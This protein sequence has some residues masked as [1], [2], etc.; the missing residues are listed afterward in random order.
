VERQ[1]LDGDRIF[2]LGGFLSPKECDDLIAL[3]ERAGYEEATITT[4]FGPVMNKGVRD[5]ARLIHDDPDLAARLWERARSHLPGS[6]GRWRAVGLNERFRFYRY[7]PGEKFA[8]HFDGAYERDSGERSFLTLM[9]YLNG[10]C[11]GGET[12]FYGYSNRPPLHRVR[13]EAGKALVFAHRLLHEGAPVLAGRKYVLRTDVM[14]RYV[15]PE[16]EGAG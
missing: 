13:P 7:D 16:E 12:N 2:T 8:P 6:V 9:V 5:N 11:E 3:S 10:S 15:R 4:A 14:Y 1:E